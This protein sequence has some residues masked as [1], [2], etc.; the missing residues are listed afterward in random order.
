[1]SIRLIRKTRRPCR[2][3]D[4]SPLDFISV[5]ADA[6]KSPLVGVDQVGEFP[7]P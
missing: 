2:R 3:Q 1:M 5:I 6:G 4:A 7:Q